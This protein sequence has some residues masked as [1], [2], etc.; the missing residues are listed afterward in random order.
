M[1]YRRID[2]AKDPRRA[3]FDYFRTLANPYV[4]VTVP[5]DV[6]GVWERSRRMGDSLFLR[7]LYAVVRG[8]NA[9]PQLRRRIR[10]DGTVVEYDSCPSS[11]IVPLPEDAYCYCT[12]DCRRPYG[13]FLPYALAEQE[14]ARAAASLDDGDQESLFFLSCVPWFSFTSLI[15]PTPAPADS[16]PRLTWGR[17]EKREGRMELPLAILAHHALVDGVHIAR[18]YEAVA[19]EMKALA[20]A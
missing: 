2:M 12:L 5:V 16:N 4:G 6:T 8:A 20:E 9:V 3:Q 10:A 13:E 17:C 1:C 14:R 18:F 15:Q 7:V 11:H 19:A